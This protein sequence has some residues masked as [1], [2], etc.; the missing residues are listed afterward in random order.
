MVF[1][2]LLVAPVVIWVLAFDTAEA[3]AVLVATSWL[4]RAV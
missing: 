3:A 4:K 1:V 2:R